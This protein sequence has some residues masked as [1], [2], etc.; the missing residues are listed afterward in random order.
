MAEEDSGSVPAIHEEFDWPTIPG[1]TREHVIA[2]GRSSSPEAFYDMLTAGKRGKHRCPFCDLKYLSGEVV[3]ENQYAYIVVPP[4]IF[5]RHAGALAKKFVIVLKRHTFDPSS[6][7]DAEVIAMQRCRRQ[8]KKRFGCY[9]KGAGGASYTRHGSTIFNAGTVIG[10]LHENVDE[11]NGLAEIRPPIYKDK[12]GWQKDFDRL[13]NYLVAYV[14]GMSREEY[15]DAY[16]R[17]HDHQY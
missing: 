8:L 2:L 6:L 10:H 3:Y 13:R 7:S 16:V 12:K 17:H 1:L 5:N 4:G 14:S 9:A 11:P 15:I